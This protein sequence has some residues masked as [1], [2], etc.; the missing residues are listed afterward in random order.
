MDALRCAK[1]IVL[2]LRNS[3][4]T[5]YFAGGWVRDRLLGNT[6]SDIDIATDAH[7]DEITQIFPDHVLVGA[8]FGVV[9][10]LYGDHQFEVATFR[11]DLLYENGR[12]PTAV[13]L[14]ATPQEDAERRDFTI[15]GMFFDPVSEIIYDFVGGKADLEKKVIRTIGNPEE[16]F[17]ED[18]LR[19]I[20]GVRFAYG[21][22]FSL[23]EETKK[24][25]SA[26]SSTLIPAVSME[27][28]W[29]EFCKMREKMSQDRHSFKNALLE[30]H[31]LNLLQTIFPP[32]QNAS[33]DDIA[34]RLQGIETLA[35][36]VP[37]ILFLVQLFEEADQTFAQNLHQYLRASREEG[38]WIESYFEIKKSPLK[39]LEPHAIAKMLA[40]PRF[41]ICFEILLSKMNPTEKAEWSNWYAKTAHELD[42]F[43]HRLRKKEPL[44]RAK[45]LEELGIC[46]GKQMGQ[47]LELAERIAINMH[48]QDKQEIIHQL[49]LSPEWTK[50]S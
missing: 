23:D 9:L 44:V 18:R 47:F 20:R 17:Q 27:R 40:N 34:L 25:I 41:A 22:G 28:I 12:Q 43:I 49:Q 33:S 7:P 26:L 46:P 3:G 4:H 31:A 48:L 13:H 14:K 1:E 2:E 38:K 32:L 6:S 5:A 16:R 30:M 10:V 19:M 24:A 11:K 45:D 15:N 39:T 36:H 50:P 29:Q 35:S 21:L 8:Q 37:T 42:F